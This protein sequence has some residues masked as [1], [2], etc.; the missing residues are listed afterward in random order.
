MDFCD[1]CSLF[2][3][4]ILEAFYPRYSFLYFLKISSLRSFSRCVGRGEVSNGWGDLES[5]LRDTCSHYLS[6][7]RGYF[8]LH[9]E[10]QYPASSKVD[11]NQQSIAWKA[12]GEP[13]RPLRSP[14]FLCFWKDCLLF[15]TSRPALDDA[16]TY[17][18]LPGR[19]MEIRQVVKQGPRLWMT[20]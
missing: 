9:Q 5:P 17:M 6:R 16:W 7:Q 1:H 3:L 19:E 10:W 4:W 15:W 12:G 2:H 8:F 11:S 18:D 20:C 13:T 14:S